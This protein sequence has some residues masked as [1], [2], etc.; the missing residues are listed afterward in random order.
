MSDS[1]IM[2]LDAFVRS[3]SII[4]CTHARTFSSSDSAFSRAFT[5]LLTRTYL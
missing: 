2:P 4:C 5:P 3:I 1:T